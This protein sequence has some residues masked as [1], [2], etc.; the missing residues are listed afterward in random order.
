MTKE[1]D[2]PYDQTR[3]HRLRSTWHENHGNFLIGIVVIIFLA[4]NG[5]LVYRQNRFV[6]PRFPDG[7]LIETPPAPQS[8]SGEASVLA[9]SAIGIRVTG[10][11]SDVG[12]IQIALYDS[13][14]SLNGAEGAFL[15]QSVSI[16][17]RQAVLMIPATELPEQIAIVAFHDENL[18]GQLNRNRLGIALERYGHSG[19]KREQTGP[20]RFKDVVISCPAAGETIDL[21][22]R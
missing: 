6:P 14:D 15:V 22:I 16:V 11:V 1:N 8:D 12:E 2:D 5:I 20:P 10:A 18:D 7:D 3:S 4:G 19:S 9:D 21:S 17:D 13:E